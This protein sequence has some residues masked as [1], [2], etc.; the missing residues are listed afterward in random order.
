MTY[1]T[2]SFLEFIILHSLITTLLI[3]LRENQHEMFE[4]KIITICLSLAPYSSMSVTVT[5]PEVVV[6]WT[7][8]EK[9]ALVSGVIK[10]GENNWPT[11]SRL[12]RPY[13]TADK[14]IELFSAKN[15]A[16]KY[17]FLVEQVIALSKKQALNTSIHYLVNFSNCHVR[18]ELGY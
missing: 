17:D 12:M 1:S 14:A 4:D 18:L 7:S 10:K 5:I 2:V 9:L 16:I 8:L 15:C 6:E 13:I 3:Y 11:I